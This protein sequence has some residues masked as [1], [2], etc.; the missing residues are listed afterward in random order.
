MADF[1]SGVD[2]AVPDA[3]SP[4]ASCPPT[5]L[6]LGGTD[7]AA[8]GWSTIMQAPATVSYGTDYVHLQ[9]STN[10]GASSG[11]QLLLRYPNAVEVGKPFKLQV[12]MLV[13]S[14][15]AH[16]TLDSAAAIMGSLTG[17]FGS[18]TERGQMIYLDSGKIG[19]ADDSQSFSTSVKDNTY[20]TYVLSVDASNVARVS[21]DGNPA[22]M[23][24]NFVTNGTIAIGDQTNDS[25]VDS[26]LRIKS[27][28]KLCP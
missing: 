28:S 16:N 13:E 11:G 23:R 8:Q 21:V 3:A 14:V 1:A 5:L 4:D 15:N 26:A 6:L 25:N 9:T 17:N 10:S 24:N 2:A 20:H 7:V 12:L 19:W 18:S 22:L 27:V